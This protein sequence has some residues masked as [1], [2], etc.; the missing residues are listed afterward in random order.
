MLEG[1]LASV[2]LIGVSLIGVSVILA[3]NSQSFFPIAAIYVK[4]LLM[5]RIRLPNVTSKLGL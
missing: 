3:M 5:N 4:S 2:S 1:T